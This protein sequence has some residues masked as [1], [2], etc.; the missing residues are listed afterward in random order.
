MDANT[1]LLPYRDDED[2]ERRDEE[3]GV[4]AKSPSSFDGG[5]S[6]RCFQLPCRGRWGDTL[7]WLGS[8]CRLIVTSV[9]IVAL[10]GFL[11]LAFIFAS[12]IF[13]GSR[14]CYTGFDGYQCHP[15]ISHFW[16]QYSPYFSL[17]HVSEISPEIPGGCDITFVQ[18]LSRHGARYPTEFKTEVYA[19]LISEIQSN[20]TTYHG[21]FTFLKDFEY[22]LGADDLTAFG[23]TQMVDSGSTFYQ[24]YKDLAQ[25]TV[26]FIRASGSD[27]VIVSAEKFIEGFHTVKKE[28]PLS[29]KND[30]VPVVGVVISEEPESNNTLNHGTC[31]EFDSDRYLSN[32]AQELFLNVFAPPIQTRVNAN[33]PGANVTLDSIP[34]LMDLCSF[35]TIADTS[36][37][38]KLSPFCSLFT[39]PEWVEYDYYQSVGKYYGYGSGH[40]LGPTQGVGFV[41]ELIAR[42][43]SSPIRGHASINRT[44]DEDSE[45][46]PLNASMYADFSHDN[47]MTSIYAALGL[48]NDTAPLSKTSLQTVEETKGYSTSWTVPFAGRAY[49]EKMECSGEDEE[50]V[51]V[52]VN[53]RVVPL[54][55]CEVDELGRCKLD[56][57]VDGLTF[58]RNGGHW[59]KCLA[60]P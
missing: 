36:D 21:G 59:G 48:Y 30:S 46:F 2:L 12:P 49:I 37:A 39:E 9:A 55:G 52:L 58:A 32:Y 41:N 17:G 25:H 34:Y 13:R 29:M 1:S 53:E 43:T 27:R 40:P 60:D 33:L 10:F 45:T 28:D 3:G 23:E 42:L 57:F 22:S 20:A 51:R 24:R 18:L 50:L 35:Q 11:I 8:K 44:L 38:S 16:G 5:A 56:D 4:R 47:T 6:R 54:H 15:K 7:G 14:P 26:P 19:D 31:D